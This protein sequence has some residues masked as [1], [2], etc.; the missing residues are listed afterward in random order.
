MMIAASDRHHQHDPTQRHATRADGTALAIAIAQRLACDA[1]VVTVAHDAAGKVTHSSRR[2]RRVSTTLRRALSNR[3]S[4]C[5][6]PGCTSRRAEA[7][8][9]VAWPRGATTL[10]NLCSLCRRHHRLEHEHGYRIATGADGELR[11]FRRDQPGGF[12]AAR[13]AR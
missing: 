6:F 7:H 8:H 13:T 9:I 12:A 3:E 11:F 10:R 2:M 4:G 5:R 1:P